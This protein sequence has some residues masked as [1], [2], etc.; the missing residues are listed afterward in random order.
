MTKD[1][2]RQQLFKIAIVGA[3]MGGLSLAHMILA[4]EKK[5]PHAQITLF[6]KKGRF[7]GRVKTIRTYDGWYE[8]GASRIADTHRR[9]RQFARAL[10]CKEEA[11][12]TS[13]D[14]RT[15]LP[16]VAKK[17]RTIRDRFVRSFG[18]DALGSL[19]WHDV[20]TVMIPD[21]A[22]R[23]DVIKRWGFS[24][25]LTQ[26]NAFDF[27]EHAMPQYL[28][29][30]YF[31]L[32]GGLQT[33]V[34]KAIERLQTAPWKRRVQIRSSARLTHMD[35]VRVKTRIKI[36]IE[37]ESDAQASRLPLSCK[38]SQK[39]SSPTSEVFDAVFTALT[40]EALAELQG[41]PA[42][43][44]HLWSSVSR[45][46][47]IRVYA[48]YD[49]VASDKVSHAKQSNVKRGSNGTRRQKTSF[50]HKRSR[51]RAITDLCK[52]TIRSTSLCRCTSTHSPRWSQL[53]YC[54][55]RH[56]D[57]LYNLLRMSKGLD[58]LRTL[59]S[60]T[61]GQA[62]G[63]FKATDVYYWKSGTHSWKPKL[64]SVDHYE[65]VLQ[66]DTKVPWFVVGASFSHYQ[67]WMEGALETAHDAYA[68]WC[69][70]AQEWFG[71]NEK[72][73]KRA[74]KHPKLCKSALTLHKTC[75]KADKAWTMA[76]VHQKQYVALD[77]YVYD[78]KDI[79]ERHPGGAAVLQKMLGKDISEAYHRI[80]HSS[81]ARAWVEE[82]CVGRLA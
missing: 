59:V 29:S 48:S 47:L 14:Q 76:E 19:T 7:G 82:H 8:A 68:R 4:D 64:L 27:W 56:A 42:R 35:V 20:L 15:L 50:K 12:P 58:L 51:R 73:R 57:H 53:A 41:L 9:V 6:E 23:E 26:M 31:T 28:C 40:P 71:V 38:P 46:R 77:G 75:K 39:T 13:Y 3:G 5:W 44:D 25:T 81:T 2:H 18:Q 67:H 36:R 1:T 66:P 17:F 60:G 79:V 49:K 54:D 80:G 69:R 30:S 43:Y 32:D 55:D 74:I 52:T 10:G 45:N 63:Q 62:W 78:V 72:I 65:R 37:Y 22:E 34:D 33:M 24:S 70:Y 21:H 11:L 16:P 61:I